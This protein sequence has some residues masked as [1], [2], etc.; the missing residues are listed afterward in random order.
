MQSFFFIRKMALLGAV[1]LLCLLIFTSCSSKPNKQ[2]LSR[3]DDARIE[4][5]AAEAQLKTLK[6]EREKLE[7]E[8]EKLKQSLKEKTESVNDAKSNI[9]DK[10]SK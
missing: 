8:L 9:P 3:I 6:K 7:Q 2:E 10:S 1:F 5:E 4:A